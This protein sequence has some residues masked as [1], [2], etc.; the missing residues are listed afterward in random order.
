MSP[1]LRRL[2]LTSGK[3]TTGPR[4]FLRAFANV[5]PRS[6][7]S[8]REP[9]D[10]RALL[11]PTRRQLVILAGVE[12]PV[13]EMGRRKVGFQ[14]QERLVRGIQSEGTDWR[15]LP[16]GQVQHIDPRRRIGDDYVA[17]SRREGNGG[18]RAPV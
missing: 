13:D 8:G 18:R 12:E 1:A 5:S 15:L 10:R 9:L 16:E 4:A 3:T 2:R 6:L 14:L 7:R 17:E 11:R